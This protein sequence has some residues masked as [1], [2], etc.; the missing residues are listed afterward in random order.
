MTPR[1]WTPDRGVPDGARARAYLRHEQARARARWR[2]VR[3]PRVDPILERRAAVTVTQ[4]NSNRDGV[5]NG[6]T[7]GLGYTASTVGNLLVYSFLNFNPSPQRTVVSVL[8]NNSNTVTAFPSG[9]RVITTGNYAG[10]CTGVYYQVV[11][12][13]SV[14]INIT[15]SGATQFWEG[16]VYE[17]AGLATPTADGFVH[18][19]TQSAGTTTYTGLPLTTTGASGI[20]FGFSADVN[21]VQNP[22]TG[23]AFT[24]GS[25]NFGSGG[26]D[27]IC[28]LISTAVGTYTPVW[29]G[30]GTG[31][32][33]LETW[34]FKDGSGGGGAKSLASRHRS[35]RVFQRRF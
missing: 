27:A 1:L 21:A 13:A 30:S 20:V 17:I 10:C 33:L 31:A 29:L 5:T 15:F 3:D 8:D 7:F 12:T 28:S 34:A 26:S 23:N 6:T 16:A 11:A 14:Q 19:D 25:E 22:K 9:Q 18:D 2:H 24:A 32:T 35:T 4:H